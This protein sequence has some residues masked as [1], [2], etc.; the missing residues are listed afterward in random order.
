MSDDDTSKMAPGLI[1][2]FAPEE[3]EEE[4]DGRRRRR[5]KGQRRSKSSV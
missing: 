5:R 4:G 1:K 2:A 3:K